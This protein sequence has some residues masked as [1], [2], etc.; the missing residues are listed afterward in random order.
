[1]T[2]VHTTN[3]TTC[4]CRALLQAMHPAC[5]PVAAAAGWDCFVAVSQLENN[6][7]DALLGGSCRVLHFPMLSVWCC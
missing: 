4:C 2:L 1:M 3:S 6:D 5:L 7:L